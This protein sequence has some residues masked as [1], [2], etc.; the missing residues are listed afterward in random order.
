MG[1]WNFLRKWKKIQ[2]LPWDSYRLA[3]LG[4][5]IYGKIHGGLKKNSP[6]TEVYK[7]SYE[8]NYWYSAIMCC[9]SFGSTIPPWGTREGT[10][11][12]NA[13][14]GDGR[15]KCWRSHYSLDFIM[16]FKTSKLKIAT[17]LSLDFFVTRSTRVTLPRKKTRWKKFFCG[18]YE[19]NEYLTSRIIK[20]RWRHLRLQVLMNEL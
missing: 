15:D 8:Q 18:K 16:I 10:S 4:F 5:V 1:I 17:K 19:Q 14:G 3:D 6:Q 12:W 9:S 13:P 20:Y 2:N 11:P 7:P